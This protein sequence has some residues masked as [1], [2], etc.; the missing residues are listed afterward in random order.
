MNFAKHRSNG[1]V[2]DLVCKGLDFSVEGISGVVRKDWERLKKEDKI[3]S[4]HYTIIFNKVCE[5]V[6]GKLFSLDKEKSNESDKQ[7]QFFNSLVKEFLRYYNQYKSYVETLGAGQKQL[8]FIAI[9]VF[10]IP[11][12]AK[13]IS[14]I[15]AQTEPFICERILPSSSKTAVEN[16]FEFIDYKLTQQNPP[17]NLKEC[18]RNDILNPEYEK[19]QR[20]P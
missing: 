3:T 8:D 12:V 10:F 9:S 1:F 20:N 19:R 11:F 18:L 13:A 16:V 6:V 14:Y 4:E 7:I 2:V 17:K 15:T 5:A